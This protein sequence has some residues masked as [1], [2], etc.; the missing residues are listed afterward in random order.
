MGAAIMHE[1]KCWIVTRWP[2]LL[3]RKT[4]SP[5]HEKYC[6]A[7]VKTCNRF[8]KITNCD[9]QQLDIGEPKGSFSKL[10][11]TFAVQKCE[12]FPMLNPNLAEYCQPNWESTKNLIPKLPEKA[13]IMGLKCHQILP[14]DS[15]AHDKE[16]Q[17]LWHFK[18]FSGYKS[19]K[20]RNR[21]DL[22]VESTDL[23]D[24][25]QLGKHESLIVFHSCKCWLVFGVFGYLDKRS[26]KTKS[27]F[28]YS[29][30]LRRKACRQQD[31]CKIVPDNV[32]NQKL[33]NDVQKDFLYSYEHCFKVANCLHQTFSCYHLR[34]GPI[35]L[36]NK[37]QNLPPHTSYK[38]I[39]HPESYPKFN[40]YQLTLK[41]CKYLKH[42]ENFIVTPYDLQLC[43]K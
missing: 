40:F 25:S 6:Q 12:L 38:V 11:K 23:S 32:Y 29:F 34:R 19:R 1:C 14:L 13:V 18:P 22:A 27:K 41:L 3:F 43:K 24:F 42:T 2:M 15:T 20:N 26:D 7:A 31:S 21:L 36:E 4:K 28:N 30:A 17:D 9:G 8:F 33:A 5:M 39:E 35:L 16:N 10:Y 37:E